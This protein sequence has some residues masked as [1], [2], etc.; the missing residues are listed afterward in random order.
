MR[1]LV[2]EVDI[3]GTSCRVRKM[4]ALDGMVLLKFVAEKCMPLFN[5]VEAL[6]GGTPENPAPE[7][8]PISNEAFLSV[9][10]KM[11]GSITNDEIRRLMTDCLHYAEVELRAGWTPIMDGKR[12]AV[13]DM[14][15]DVGACLKLCIEVIVFNFADF[16]GENGLHLNLAA[17]NSS[18][19]NA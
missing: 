9:L 17:L 1:E 19:P 11:L 12:F 2:K 7:N 16:F 15:Y 10:Q 18:K 6:A 8:A 14:E 5:S 3:N 4:N 13:E